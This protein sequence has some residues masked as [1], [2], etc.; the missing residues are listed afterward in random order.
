MMNCWWVLDQLQSSTHVQYATTQP[1]E[2]LL[3]D[4]AGAADSTSATSVALRLWARGLLASILGPRAASSIAMT[5]I[6][7]IVAE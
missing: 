5:D 6:L 1:A 4:D 7:S 2:H 3:W